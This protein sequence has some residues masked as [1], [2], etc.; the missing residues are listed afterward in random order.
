MVIEEKRKEKSSEETESC[1]DGDFDILKTRGFYNKK[2]E[3][4]HDE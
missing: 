4:F 2:K 1:R 3:G